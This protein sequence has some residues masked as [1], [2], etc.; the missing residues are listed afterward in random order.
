MEDVRY[1]WKED[2]NNIEK[3]CVIPTLHQ[4]ILSLSAIFK[5]YPNATEIKRDKNNLLKARLTASFST[6]PT[7]AFVLRRSN[8]LLELIFNE[9]NNIEKYDLNKLHLYTTI[10]RV[11]TITLLYNY[12]IIITL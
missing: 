8:I 4:N 9:L 3:V 2:N 12:D 7:F 10:F 6:T 11:A 5:Q 1:Q